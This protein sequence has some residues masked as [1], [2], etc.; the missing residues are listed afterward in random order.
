MRWL[1]QLAPGHITLA[2]ARTPEGP[3]A[4]VLHR[5]RYY[6]HVSLCVGESSTNGGADQSCA[7]YPMCRA[8]TPRGRIVASLLSVGA[9]L[10]VVMHLAPASTATSETVSDHLGRA[11]A[12]GLIGAA[13]GPPCG[14]ATDATYLS[15]AFAV[16][17]RI[18][19]EER[20]GAEVTRDLNTIEADRVLANAV[21]AG[22]LATVQSEVFAL[23]HNHQ[24]VVRL[25]VL[26]ASSDIRARPRP[27]R[28]VSCGLSR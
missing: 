24:H 17:L 13:A 25:R 16:A 14:A 22:D 8:M 1:Y 11:I 28:G 7:N 15:T 5:I 4:I 19:A 12:G 2:E 20:G 23:I 10:A 9:I 27:S 18:S 21:A 3:I 26:R 6:G